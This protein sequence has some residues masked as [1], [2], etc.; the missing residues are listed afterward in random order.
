MMYEFDLRPQMAVDDVK[1]LLPSREDLW[2]DTTEEETDITIIPTMTIAEALETLYIEKRLPAKLSEFSVGILI[3]AIYRHTK[4]ML[5]QATRLSSWTPSA[6]PERGTVAQQSVTQPHWL[7]ATQMA[8]KWRN[9]ACDSLDILH[10][11]ANSKVAKLAGFEHHTILHLHLARIITITPTNCVKTLAATLAATTS[12][13]GQSSHSRLVCSARTELV[14][15]AVRDRYKARLA[16]IHCAALY[17]HVRRY[18]CNS[19]QEPYAIYIATL[20]LWGFSIVMQ[21]PEVT[22]AI[23]IDG[24]DDPDPNFCHLDRPLDDE[25]VQLFVR[26]GHRMCPHISKIGNIFHPEAPPKVLAEGLYLLTA[27]SQT[28]SCSDPELHERH[29]M[30]RMT[31]GIER[32]Y[33]KVLN[34]IYQK[35]TQ[36]ETSA[37]NPDGLGYPW[38]TAS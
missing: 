13:S 1:A 37:A 16:V 33:A 15:W 20:V 14:Q 22:E 18:S 4:S 19:I 7:P 17:W 5:S 3:H 27:S 23:S 26:V 34:D 31:W 12:D 35:A 30:R 29:D 6:V 8:S 10:W 32:S 38:N 9:S 24:E 25:L 2:Q 11:H 36:H 28:P 21:L